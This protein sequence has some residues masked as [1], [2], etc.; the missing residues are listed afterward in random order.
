MEQ[1][2]KAKAHSQE[3]IIGILK[4]VEAG[5]KVAEVCRKHGISDASFYSWRKKYQGMNVDEAKRLKKLEDENARLKKL[6]ADQA[7]DI[8]MLKEINSKKW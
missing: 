5:A 2:M 7:L 8:A 4:E 1:K 6:I 3:K